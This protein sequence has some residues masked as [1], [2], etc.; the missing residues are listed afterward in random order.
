MYTTASTGFQCSAHAYSSLVIPY[1][2][3][4]SFNSNQDIYVN[5]VSEPKHLQF[6]SP[7]FRSESNFKHFENQPVHQN[8]STTS[9]CRC[10][11]LCD[12]ICNYDKVATPTYTGYGDEQKWHNFISLFEKVCDLNE[13]DTETR[14][15]QLLISLRDE[16]LEFVDS[17]L[18][19]DTKDY[20]RLKSALADR[21]SIRDDK[22]NFLAQFKSRDQHLNESIETFLQD[23]WHLAERAFLEVSNSSDSFYLIVADKFIGG[24]INTDTRKH[25]LLNRFQYH[26]NGADM[27]KDLLNAAML[28]ET[29]MSIES[30]RYEANAGT[31]SKSVNGD[32][33]HSYSNHAKNTKSMNQFNDPHSYEFTGTLESNTEFSDSCCQVHDNALLTDI[34][35]CTCRSSSVSC[36]INEKYLPSTMSQDPG[37]TYEDIQKEQ[38]LVGLNEWSVSHETSQHPEQ[39]VST[40]DNSYMSDLLSLGNDPWADSLAIQNKDLTSEEPLQESVKSAVLPLEDLV[41]LEYKPCVISP[42]PSLKEDEITTFG[43]L[44]PLSGLQEN[45]SSCEKHNQACTSGRS[46]HFPNDSIPAMCTDNKILSK[47][48]EGGYPISDLD[49]ENVKLKL[50]SDIAQREMKLGSLISNKWDHLR[51][52]KVKLRCNVDN[53]STQGRS[54]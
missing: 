14:R 33:P 30:C 43:S 23:L 3:S 51:Q 34:D 10:F 54:L 42:D 29:V 22:A 7:P 16:A 20:T 49:R 38:Q 1:A 8:A 31:I 11:S 9:K 52:K 35:T 27:L 37:F 4:I 28:Y 5:N 50:N 13:Y 44:N 39:Y 18:V 47:L 41:S 15:K 25:L 12:N 36:D 53:I 48:T 2:Y 26:C 32:N 40:I 46:S 6:K 45:R 19:K 24:L 21:F 17:L